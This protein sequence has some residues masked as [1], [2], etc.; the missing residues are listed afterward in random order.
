MPDS[1]LLTASW[2]DIQS[3]SS[4]VDRTWWWVVL[5]GLLYRIPH[6]VAG[7][8]G[9]SVQ[10]TFQNFRPACLLAAV[11]PRSLDA[12]YELVIAGLA[13]MS[14]NHPCS[15][16][17]MTP[18]CV[19]SIR[20]SADPKGKFDARKSSHKMRFFPEMNLASLKITASPAT[21]CRKTYLDTVLSLS[22]E[23]LIAPRSARETS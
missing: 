10:P 18:K 11:W 5:G 20:H 1:S 2:S 12:P 23:V 14:R 21:T 6:S 19:G 17:R 8:C 13:K 16:P 15:T 22:S 4:M 7:L 3:S 9:P